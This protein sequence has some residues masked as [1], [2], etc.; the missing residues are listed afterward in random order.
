MVAPE[1]GLE[2]GTGPEMVGLKFSGA[3]FELR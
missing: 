2:G 1:W 3:E